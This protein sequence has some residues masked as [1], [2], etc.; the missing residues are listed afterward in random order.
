MREEEGEQERGEER[1][2]KGRIREGLFVVLTSSQ[3]F[4][5][6]TVHC[7]ALSQLT[8]P[9]YSSYNS[10]FTSLTVHHAFIYPC[11]HVIV[12]APYF[13]HRKSTF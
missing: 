5:Y 7:L 9:I 13:R 12:E 3:Q 8:E 6:S 1:G 11:I 2:G 10:S 4:L